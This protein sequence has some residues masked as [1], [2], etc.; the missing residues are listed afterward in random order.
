[1]SARFALPVKVLLIVSALALSACR[2]PDRF[3]SGG[4]RSRGTVGVGDVAGERGD[5]APHPEAHPRR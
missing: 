1:M 5:R 4:P 2:N 3:G